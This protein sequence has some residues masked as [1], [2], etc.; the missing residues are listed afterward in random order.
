M[1]R[2]RR[3][4][5]SQGFLTFL[6]ELKQAPWIGNRK[7]W[8]DFL[9]HFTDIK[10]AVSVL[11]SGFL[12]SRD[13]VERRRIGFT[14]SA[15][16]EIIDRTDA[17]LT[18]YVRFYFRPRTPTQYR[19]E[20]FRPLN[21]LFQGA[22][23]PVPI[24]FLFD[25]REIISLNDTRFSNGSLARREHNL[26]TTADKFTQLPFRDIYHN[27]SFS[28]ENRERIINAR[29][30]EVIYPKRISLD[31]LKYIC[32]RSQAEY[33]TLYNL[34]SPSPVVWNRWEPKVRT[35][36]PHSLFNQKWLYIK[37][38]TLTKKLI[39]LNFNLPDE[40]ERKYH[41]PFKIRVDIK[42]QLMSKT[43]YFEKEYI[44]IVSELTNARLNLNLSDE[45]IS[46]DVRVSIDGSL[47]Y[48]GRYAEVDG[49][50]F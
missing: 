16:S 41:G 8:V 37:D 24:Y 36:N 40:N 17:T 12:F 39:S 15:S 50:P 30:A 29:H 45:N 27:T 1:S 18:D 3:K 4:P 47:A 26:F 6:D 11:N 2:T 20:G 19:N 46:Y 23:C 7:W 13:E 5:D 49:I 34:L 22:H 35:C 14:D 28:L 31:Y 25:I 38:V 42:D 32:C 9:F 43:Y 44:D 33:E 48:L 10:N 21:Q